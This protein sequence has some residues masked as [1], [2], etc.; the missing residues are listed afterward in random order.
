MRLPSQPYF[1]VSELCKR[2]TKVKHVGSNR[3]LW[4]VHL[5]LGKLMVLTLVPKSTSAASG[6][7][8]IA[9]YLMMKPFR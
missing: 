1:P 9:H 3:T 8:E 6:T 5:Q 2:T 7:E 4:I